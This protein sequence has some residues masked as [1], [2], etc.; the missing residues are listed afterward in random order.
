MDQTRDCTVRNRKREGQSPY[1]VMARR[2]GQ[3][4]AIFRID[5]EEHTLVHQ[6]CEIIAIPG[7]T[8]TF[9]AK[10]ASKKANPE[11]MASGRPDTNMS[12]DRL[13]DEYS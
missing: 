1:E 10:H 8:I 11:W 13:K 12:T 3:V 9:S 5:I 7:T 4:T 6:Q 2:M